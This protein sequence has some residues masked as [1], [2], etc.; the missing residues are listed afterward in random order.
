MF[1]QAAKIFLI[2]P[3]NYQIKGGSDTKTSGENS[4]LPPYNDST[5]RLFLRKYNIWNKKFDD[6]KHG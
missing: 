5:V 4:R 6:F 3:F 2:K 1:S